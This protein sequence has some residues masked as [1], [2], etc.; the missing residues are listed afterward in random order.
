MVLICDITGTG[1]H[2]GS[3]CSGSASTSISNGNNT[4]VT[5]EGSLV[6]TDS[7]IL[8]VSPHTPPDCM[9]PPSGHSYP[10]TDLQQSFVTIEGEKIVLI[11]DSYSSDSTV[12]T[13][14]GINTFCQI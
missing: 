1:V 10:I 12:I 4:F 9:S 13:N 14:A 11:G 5:I 3:I 6:V 7:N 8:T 2:T